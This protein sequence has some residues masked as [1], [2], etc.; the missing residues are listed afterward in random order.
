MPTQLVCSRNLPRFKI[1]V[2]ENYRGD[3]MMMKTLLMIST[4]TMIIMI[5]TTIV[6]T[7][8]VSSNAQ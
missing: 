3:L 2:T 6:I 4:M 5:M 1:V 7:I 8:R